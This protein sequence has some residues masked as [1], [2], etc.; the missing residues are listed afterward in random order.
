ML[1]NQQATFTF[2]LDSVLIVCI[3]DPLGLLLKS[4]CYLTEKYVLMV[5]NYRF[6][7]SE[8]KKKTLKTLTFE[9]Q[10]LITSGSL[11]NDYEM[12]YTNTL[13]TNEACK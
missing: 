6:P 10:L 5:I 9:Q 8:K 3:F 11:N 7:V 4:Y 2:C 13:I 12:R 1:E